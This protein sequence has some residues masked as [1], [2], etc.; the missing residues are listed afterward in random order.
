ME[1]AERKRLARGCLPAAPSPSPSPSPSAAKGGL[2]KGHS[3]SLCTC[4][5]DNALLHLWM[6]FSATMHLARLPPRPPS[7]WPKPLRAP[8]PEA[9]ARTPDHKTFGGSPPTFCAVSR[10][11]PSHDGSPPICMQLL[12]SPSQALPYR[13]NYSPGATARPLLPPV[14]ARSLSLSVRPSCIPTSRGSPR[15]G[16]EHSLPKR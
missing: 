2:L 10:P 8:L 3:P 16:S 11:S 13:S 5:E 7:L 15:V 9:T 12:S 6:E 4:T 1:R 14:T